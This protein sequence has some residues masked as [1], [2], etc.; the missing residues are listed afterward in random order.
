MKISTSHGRKTFRVLPRGPYS[1]EASASFLCGFTPASG[2][3]ARLDDGRLVIAFLDETR[4]APVTVALAQRGDDLE[5]TGE[6]HHGAQAIDEDALV[7]QVTRILS[8]DHD[9]GG[10]ATIAAR[11][12]AV[13]ALLDA[14]PGFRPVCFP[15][16]YEAAVWGVLAQRISMP[17]AAAIKQ[18]L[19]VATGSIAE[20]YGRTYHPA[21]APQALLSLQSFAGLSAEKL[22]RLHAVALAALDG[23]LATARLRAMPRADAVHELEAIRGVGPWTAEHIVMR[24]C[25]AI[26]ELPASEPRVLRAIAEAYGLASVPTAAEAQRI[27]ESW[28]PYRMWISV[29]MVSNL[30][31]T[32]RWNAPGRLAS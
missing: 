31:R 23:K 17:V 27:A 9:A 24:G 2:A 14:A 20:G 8:L 19:A 22:A 12:P 18:R 30:R 5:V 6:L 16:A 15:S 21:P 28:R 3:S 32:P 7:A 11:D 29:L 4:Y 26:D 13:G 1:L 10:L 25:G